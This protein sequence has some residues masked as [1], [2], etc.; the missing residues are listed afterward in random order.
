MG[1]M[2]KLKAALGQH[3]DKVDDG[4]DRA[5]DTVDRRTGDKYTD[6]VDQGQAAA[7]D[8]AEKFRRGDDTPG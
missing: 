6:K 5:G 7:K 2:D 3:G 8:A 4:V 1:L